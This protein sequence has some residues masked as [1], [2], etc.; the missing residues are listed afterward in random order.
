MESFAQLLAR[1]MRRIGISD[2]ER[3]SLFGTDL[4]T[5]E[6][7]LLAP[8]RADETGEPLGP[9]GAGDD[10]EEDLWLADLR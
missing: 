1:Y 3:Q 9:S 6:A 4:T 7:H 2:A 5:A 10:P 8:L